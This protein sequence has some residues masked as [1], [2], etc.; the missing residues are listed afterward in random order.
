MSLFLSEIRLDAS[1]PEK[2]AQIMERVEQVIKAGGSGAARLV[3][4]PWA[5]LENPTLFLVQEVSDLNQSMPEIMELYNAGLILDTR[6]RPI[7]EWEG[8][9]AAAAK[10]QK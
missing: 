2:R 5:S 3:A 1:T 4:G 9:K 10:V 7:M 6:Q 8:A